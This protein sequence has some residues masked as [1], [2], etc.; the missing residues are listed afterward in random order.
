MGRSNNMNKIKLIKL[1]KN[2]QSDPNI[3]EPKV[4]IQSDKLALSFELNSFIFSF[5]EG[6]LGKIVFNNCYSYRVG[7]PNDEGYYLN[8]NVLWNKNNFPDV[9]WDCFYQ[10]YDVP[11]SYFKDFKNLNENQSNS[12]AG[13]NHYV[14][15]MKEATFECLAESYTENI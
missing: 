9:E 1:N 5:K 14:F 11:V 15:F 4:E 13:F 7:N 10:V 6:Q 8:D 2:Y 12:S 3:A